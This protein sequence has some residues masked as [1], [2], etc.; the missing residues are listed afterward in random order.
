MPSPKFDLADPLTRGEDLAHNYRL[1]TSLADKTCHGCGRYHIV[2]PLTRWLD[3]GT[4]HK[5]DRAEFAQAVDRWATARAQAPGAVTVLVVG[6][7]DSGLLAIAAHACAKTGMLSRARFAVVDRC[8]TPLALCRDFAVRH[9]LDLTTRVATVERLPDL[10]PAQLVIVHSL[11]RFVPPETRLDCLRAWGGLVAPGG[12][13][14]LSNTFAPQSGPARSPHS[15]RLRDLAESGAFEP[16][17]PKERFIAR[18][19]EGSPWTATDVTESELLG[20]LRAAG[21][22]AHEVHTVREA[23]PGAGRL[24]AVLSRV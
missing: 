15:T 18:L 23:D 8:D 21:L 24:V 7:A 6:A 10:S 22:V 9:G 19:G 2:Y 12:R 1:A 5:S 11:L 13:M 16:A 20:L 4:A 17:E 14:I 3:V